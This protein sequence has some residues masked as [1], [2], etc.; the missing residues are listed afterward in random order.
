MSRHPRI[1][2]PVGLAVFLL[3]ALA[4][5][6]AFL[7]GNGQAANAVMHVRGYPSGSPSN[8]GNLVV[9]VCLNPAAPNAAEQPI[10]N[11]VAE[12][13]RFQGIN[14]NVTS[15]PGPGQ[16]DF[17]SV[18][19]HELGHCMGL[20]H[21]TLGPSELGS[22]D[23]GNAQLYYTKSLPNVGGFNTDDG[24]DNV[25][26]SRDDVRVDDT[27]LHW[28]RNGVNNPFADLPA[29]V[30]QNTYS[31]S[32]LNLPVG[33]LY[34]EAATSHSPCAP[35][36][37]ATTSSLP[38]RVPLTQSVMMPVLCSSNAVRKLSKDDE[39]QFRIARAG[40]NGAAGNADD[41]TWTMQYVGRTTD[42]HIPISLVSD[43]ETGFA[44]CNV[45]FLLPGN[46]SG[47]GVLTQM[48]LIARSSV[49]WF[50]NQTDTTTSAPVGRIFY[51]G[52][53]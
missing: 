14:G 40:Y 38:G 50:F 51:G 3:P 20:D 15:G 29:T 16:T 37:A 10:E 45:G 28:F 5:A 49:N 36:S 34:A 32:L 22:G 6:G 26:A 12:F 21:N 2:V 18:M 43:A 33:H 48:Q 52:F 17:E 46:G 27:N 53:E 47:D 31:V 30:D 8:V 7:I 4:D 44:Q 41:Y 24:V 39:A 23:F 25:R 11:A 19:L 1:F 9:T 35:Q 13:N 42:C